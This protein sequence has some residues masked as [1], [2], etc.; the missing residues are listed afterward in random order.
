MS[1]T[2]GMDI[3]VHTVNDLKLDEIKAQTQLW[4]HSSRHLRRSY[5]EAGKKKRQ[6]PQSVTEYW[7]H[8]DEL[9]YLHGIV[10]KGEKIVILQAFIQ[11]CWHAY[12]LLSLALKNASRGHVISC[13]GP[14]WEKRLKKLLTS[15]THASRM[16]QA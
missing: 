13:F 12:M 1:I 11:K 10:F 5:K 3:Q 15:A 16:S 14:G 9:L 7:N 4:T 8:R 6:C 2:E